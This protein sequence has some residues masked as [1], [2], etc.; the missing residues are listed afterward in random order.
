M[1]PVIYTGVSYSKT[2]LDSTVTNWT[3]WIANWNG[4]D[5]QTGGGGT[6]PWGTWVV[7][8]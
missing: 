3:P 1:K 4:Q 8:R 2:W 7:W 6:G 5:P